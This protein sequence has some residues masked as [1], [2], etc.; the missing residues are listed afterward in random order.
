M[1]VFVAESKAYDL[2]LMDVQIPVMNGFQATQKIRAG[3]VP[4][5]TTSIVA[6]TAN[7]MQSDKDACYEASMNDFLTKPFGKEELSQA[8]ERHLQMPARPKDVAIMSSS[9]RA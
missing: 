8:V 2:I 4:N 5:K 9:T 3:I 1:A 7:A 6:L